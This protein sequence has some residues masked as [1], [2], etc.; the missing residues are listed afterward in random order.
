MVADAIKAMLPDNPLAA[1]SAEPYREPH[2]IWFCF[3]NNGVIE[4]PIIIVP[5]N[6]VENVGLWLEGRLDYWRLRDDR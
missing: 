2:A 6:K 1:R 3:V 4:S 5:C